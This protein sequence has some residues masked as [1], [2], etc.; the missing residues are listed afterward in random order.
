MKDLIAVPRELAGDGRRS[1]LARR[2]IAGVDLVELEDGAYQL[3]VLLTGDRAGF[4]KV[5]TLD[6]LEPI[7]V[8]FREELA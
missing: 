6:V 3:D 4:R 2:I 7:F 1:L 8:Y 5:G